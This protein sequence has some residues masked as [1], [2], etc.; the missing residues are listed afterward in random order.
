MNLDGSVDK[1]AVNIV[2][3]GKMYVQDID[4]IKDQMKEVHWKAFRKIVECGISEMAVARK[5][6]CTD[7]KDDGEFISSDKAWR[8]IRHLHRRQKT[9]FLKYGNVPNNLLNLFSTLNGKVKCSKNNS[10]L[11]KSIASIR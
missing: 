6:I 3:D 5:M 7:I 1:D 10:I 9:G 11:F 2:S 8:I 4:H